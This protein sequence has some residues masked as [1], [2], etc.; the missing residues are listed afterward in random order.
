MKFGLQIIS[1]GW[2]ASGIVTQIISL[3]SEDR[4]WLYAG[5]IMTGLGVFLCYLDYKSWKVEQRKLRS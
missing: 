2:I 4:K 1:L 5:M 3:F